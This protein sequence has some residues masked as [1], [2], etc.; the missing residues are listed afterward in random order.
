MSHSELWPREVEL[1]CE[2]SKNAMTTEN[3]LHVAMKPICV[4]AKP[5]LWQ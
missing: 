3:I 1:M 5:A 4:F 2:H